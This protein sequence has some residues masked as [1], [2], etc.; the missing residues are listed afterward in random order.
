LR[1]AR[2]LSVGA[3]ALAMLALA[4]PLSSG[5][6]GPSTDELRFTTDVPGVSTGVF[7][8]EEFNTRDSNGQL[9]RLRHSHV[10]FPP[11]TGLS[12]EAADLC[13]AS[14]DEFRSKG[15]SACPESSKIGSGQATTVTTGTPTELGPFPV[16]ATAFN[17]PGAVRIVFSSGGSYQSE[18]DLVI[19]GNAQDADVTPICVAPGETDPC[20]HGEFVPKSLTMNFPARSRTV[21]GRVVN[22]TTTPPTCPSSGEWLLSDIHTFSDGSKDTFVNHNR[23]KQSTVSGGA[24]GGGA[25]ALNLS[26]KP[27]RAHVGRRTCFRFTTTT[28][29]TPVSGAKVRFGRKRGKSDAAGQTRL[30]ERPVR[31]GLHKAVAGK[32]GFTPAAARVRVR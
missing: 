11:G 9:K 26:V 24:P 3:L 30:C 32:S 1:R 21:G 14:P 16:D 22:L 7:V 15:L 12:S 25:A 28:G 6:E 23:C 18:T 20:P 13:T 4:Q 2:L 29:G 5:E 10:E 17:A 8:T 31:R 27:R 19:H